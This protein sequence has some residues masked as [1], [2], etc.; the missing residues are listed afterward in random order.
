[1]DVRIIT[2]GFSDGSLEVVLCCLVIDVDQRNEVAFV[3]ALG[4]T[5]SN[6]LLWA[7][8]AAQTVTGSIGS[9]RGCPGLVGAAAKDP[10]TKVDEQR[11]QT[12]KTGTNDSN[13]ELNC[14]PP[15]CLIVVP[16]FVEKLSQFYFWSQTWMLFQGGPIALECDMTYR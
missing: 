2:L 10:D 8:V 11:P 7:S 14:T 16:C 13:V 3:S 1:M 15:S 9:I 12:W 5:L 4:N 6:L